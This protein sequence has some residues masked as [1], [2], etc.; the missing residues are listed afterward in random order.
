[1]FHTD[2]TRSSVGFL[3]I[4]LMAYE[5][6]GQPKQVVSPML[7]REPFFTWFRRCQ[8]LR[9]DFPSSAHVLTKRLFQFQP[10][11]YDIVVTYENLAL[12][13]IITPNTRWTE[14]PYIY[15]PPV[16]SWADHPIVILNSAALPREQRD[17][18]RDWIAFLLAPDRQRS[19]I[20]FGLR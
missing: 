20:S 13:D 11:H 14:Q 19:L 8:R 17:A 4:Y 6:L 16:T 2:P 10:D 12:L 15:Y 3:S 9:K 1:F 7:E 18:A 5:F